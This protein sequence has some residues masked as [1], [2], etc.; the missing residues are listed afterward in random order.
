MKKIVFVIM[1]IATQSLW[2]QPAFLDT[3]DVAGGF[4]N[5]VSVTHAGDGSDRLFVTQQ[6]GQIKVV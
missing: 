5:P 6:G 3:E 2:A 4:T 1:L